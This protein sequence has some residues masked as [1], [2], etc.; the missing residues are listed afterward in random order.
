MFDA[1]RVLTVVI[2]SICSLNKMHAA[3]EYGSGGSSGK[4][5]ETTEKRE[6]DARGSPKV[7][8]SRQNGAALPEETTTAM[9]TSGMAAERLCP[10]VKRENHSDAE[11]EQQSM[12]ID[13]ARP[14]R[15]SVDEV[16]A[17]ATAASRNSTKKPSV[18]AGRIPKTERE[19][20]RKRRSTDD[21]FSSNCGNPFAKKICFE[22]RERFIDSLVGTGERVTA[23]ELASRADELRAEVQVRWRQFRT[24]GVKV[25]FIFFSL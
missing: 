19:H 24:S 9:A 10:V 12:P 11:N 1:R 6:E 21:S 17:A 7:P 13:C 18:A 5:V 3:V 2:F 15:R 14:R 22:Q 16:A 8:Q 4:K 25:F 23:D 20:T